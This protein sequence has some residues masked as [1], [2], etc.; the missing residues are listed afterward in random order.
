METGNDSR[1]KVI[2][3]NVS[4]R[5]RYFKPFQARAHSDQVWMLLPMCLLF[6][7]TMTTLVATEAKSYGVMLAVS[8]C[9]CSPS[10]RASASNWSQ[11]S[12]G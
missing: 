4:R 11:P 1:Q 3:R 2:Q 9:R 7:G 12:G 10:A 5:D 6:R 8:S